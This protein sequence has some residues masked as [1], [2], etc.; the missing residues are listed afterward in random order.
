MY[1]RRPYSREVYLSVR[2]RK[3]SSRVLEFDVD[4]EKD[5]ICYSASEIFDRNEKITRDG[6]WKM[7]KVQ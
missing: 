3:E 5:L 2:D 7:I 4:V 6:R 1:L